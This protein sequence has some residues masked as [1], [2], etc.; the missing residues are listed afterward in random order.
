MI[1]GAAV[2]WQAKPLSMPLFLEQSQKNEDEAGSFDARATAPTKT[3]SCRIRSGKAAV[4]TQDAE[5]APT[6]G[7]E[8]E[9]SGC[10]TADNHGSTGRPDVQATAYQHVMPRQVAVQAERVFSGGRL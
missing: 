2:R 8:T 5:A 1:G 3:A 6:I 9:E 7:C 4:V 10:C